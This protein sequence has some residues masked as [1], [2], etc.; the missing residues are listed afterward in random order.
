MSTEPCTDTP[1]ISALEISDL[2]E[3]SACAAPASSDQSCNASAFGERLEEIDGMLNSVLRSSG[4]MTASRDRNARTAQRV[5]LED[6]FEKGAVSWQPLASDSAKQDVGLKNRPAA[7][8]TTT[9][10]TV[11]RPTTDQ[12]RE[13]RRAS[14][15][16]ANRLA[17]AFDG[18]KDHE[19]LQREE[20]TRARLQKFQSQ[21]RRSPGPGPQWI[22][23]RE[24]KLA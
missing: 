14:R 10:K 4:A 3:G 7:G 13:R 22:G 19:Q 21:S 11:E 20:D 2:A 9:E 18:A 1:R 5:C 16:V 12:D 17:S 15:H 8:E 23:K 24:S 6:S